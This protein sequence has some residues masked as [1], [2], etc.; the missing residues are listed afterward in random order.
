MSR[1]LNLD[2]TVAHVTDMCAR[3]EASISVIEPLQSGGTR[4]VLKTAHDAAVIS[5]AYGKKVM[6]GTV[7][8]FPTRLR[9]N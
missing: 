2:A 3:H 9:T 1:A 7:I 4:L 8:R 6:L 5:R